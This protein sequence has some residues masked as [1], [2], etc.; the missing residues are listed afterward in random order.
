MYLNSIFYNLKDKERFSQV[1][2]RFSLKG[3]RFK[4]TSG[5]TTDTGTQDK[6]RSKKG[7]DGKK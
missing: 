6:K 1:K 2:E 4:K 7:R 5:S 3:Q